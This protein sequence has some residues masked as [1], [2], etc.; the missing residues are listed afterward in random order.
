MVMFEIPFNFTGII[1]RQILSSRFSIIKR[2]SASEC[3]TLELIL[4]ATLFESHTHP[5][6]Q[7][8]IYWIVH[9]KLTHVN[10]I[11]VFRICSSTIS[12]LNWNA[13]RVHYGLF[14]S[15]LKSSLSIKSDGW[16]ANERINKSKCKQIKITHRRIWRRLHVLVHVPSSS[17]LVSSFC[18]MKWNEVVKTFLTSK[19]ANRSEA[20]AWTCLSF[21]RNSINGRIECEVSTTIDSILHYHWTGT[22]TIGNVVK[23]NQN[24]SY[25]KRRELYYDM[26]FYVNVA[27]VID[28]YR[29]HVLYTFWHSLLQIVR[30][31]EDEKKRPSKRMHKQSNT[32]TMYVRLHINLAWKFMHT[33]AWGQS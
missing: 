10:G 31:N 30:R 7:Q 5:H 28:I 19:V 16:M 25:E 29:P 15:C 9:R 33:F 1:W 24:R 18:K 3:Q 17:S 13:C 4:F 21:S 14:I 6:T 27:K 32:F 11:I 22:W 20:W 2:T 12:I 26:G 8:Q 23:C